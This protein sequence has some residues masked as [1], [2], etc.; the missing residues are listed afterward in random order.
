MAV[1]NTKSL[2]VS[3]ADAAVQTLD[4]IGVSHGR[5][6]RA[7]A[8]LEAVNG[9]SIGST[10]RMMRVRS[11][12]NIVAIK[13]YCDAITTCAADLGLYN[14]PGR[15]SAAGSVVSAATYASAQSLATAITTGTEI[16]F[17]ARDVANLERQVWQDAGAATDPGYWYDLAFTLTAAAGS[18]GTVSLEV[19]YVGND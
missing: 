14:V 5:L 16:Q 1:V 17:E 12:W 6:R 3:N 9:D 19:W 8:T 4:K 11:D 10:F 7:C 15:G 13:L 2:R 18:A